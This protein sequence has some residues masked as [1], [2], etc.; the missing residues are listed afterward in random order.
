VIGGWVVLGVVLA[1]CL[2]AFRSYEVAL[3][4]ARREGERWTWY[5]D[6][7]LEW[8][9]EEWVYRGGLRFDMEFSALG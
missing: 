7:E 6:L 9:I 5:E 2:C 1:A 8:E 3:H 4:D